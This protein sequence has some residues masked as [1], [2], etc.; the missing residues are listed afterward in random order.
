MDGTIVD[1]AKTVLRILNEIRLAL[2]LSPIFL[3]QIIPFLSKGGE[4]LIAVAI[5]DDPN[6]SK[7]LKLFR[8]LYFSDTLAEE[9][10]YP[11]VLD[12]L[13]HL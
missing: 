2:R 13:E 12:F 1:S 5:G 9:V 3:Q 7:H 8:D 4:D 10:L 6:V 11:G